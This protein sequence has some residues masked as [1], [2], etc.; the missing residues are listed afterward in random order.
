MQ[1]IMQL[2]IDVELV[3]TTKLYMQVQTKHDT[4]IWCQGNTHT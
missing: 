1:Y 3:G 2:Y 4:L